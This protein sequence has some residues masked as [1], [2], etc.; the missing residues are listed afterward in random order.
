M[1]LPITTEKCHRT[2]LCNA[3]LTCLMECILF[4]SKRRW[5]WKDEL[6]CVPLV[7]VKRGGCVLWQFECQASNVTSSAHLH[8]WTLPVFF[9]HCLIASSTVLCWNWA[10]VSTSR[11][12]N[13]RVS[14]IGTW[15][16]PT[17]FCIMPQMQYLTGFRSGMLA[18]HMSG[19]MNWGVSQRRSS[20]VS[21][22]RCDGALSW[23]IANTS[24]AML[25]V[26]YSSSCVSNTSR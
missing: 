23:Q 19:P 2:T 26:A 3:K 18:G 13:S 17:R 25:R 15:Y 21:R 12:R 1:N 5:L 11:C 7:A 10:H 24:P 4:P 9:R 20:T 14:R 6:C 22:V 8:R 16:R